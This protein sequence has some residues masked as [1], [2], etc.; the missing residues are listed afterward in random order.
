MENSKGCFIL[1]KDDF[2]NILLVQKGKKKSPGDWQL[3]GRDKKGKE[4]NDKCIHNVIKENLNTLI[5][6]LDEYKV[7]QDSKDENYA[8]YIGKIK[9]FMNLGKGVI[10]S[11]WINSERLSTMVMDDFSKKVLEDYFSNL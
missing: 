3:V 7:I 9:D 1:L 6:D 2:N 5:F 10:N 4:T 8:I 11:E